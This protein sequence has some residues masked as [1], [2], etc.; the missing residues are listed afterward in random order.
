MIIGIML[1]LV[2]PMISAA[3]WDSNWAKRKE[4]TITGG[5]TNLTNFTV[6]INVTYTTLMQTDFQDI[7]FID[8]ACS[9]AQTTA[10]KYELAEN[11]TSKNVLVYVKI[12]TLATGNNYIC[13]YYNNSAAT[14]N[15]DKV[16][17]WDEN[18]LAVYHFKE[19][20]GT[21][22]A[23]SKGLYNMSFVNTPV[24]GTGPIG[25]KVLL[26][27]GDT[28]YLKNNTPA[29]VIGDDSMFVEAWNTVA[30]V[31]GNKFLLS[32]WSTGGFN[33]LYRS[34]TNTYQ[35][36]VTG[37]GGLN[38][39]QNFTRAGT[40]WSY[41]AMNYNGSIGGQMNSSFAT[42]VDTLGNVLDTGID[43]RFGTNQAGT[44]PWDGNID[45]VRLSS[46]TRTEAWGKR[47]Y[48]NGLFNT[49]TFGPERSNAEV[50]ELSQ[51]Y[52][53]TTYETAIESM[54]INITYDSDA[55]SSISA[56][57]IYNGTYY[58]SNKT[59]TGDNLTFSSFKSIPVQLIPTNYSFYWNITTVN[60]SGTFYAISST[61]YQYVNFTTFGLCNSTNA[62]Q[63]QNITF[64][65]ET[66]LAAMNGSIDASTWIYWLG[67]GGVN[68]TYIFSNTSQDNKNFT[69]CLTP[70]DRTL[71]RLATVQ[72]SLTN[73]PQRKW[74]DV[75]DLT[76]AS[77]LDILYLLSSSVGLYSTYSVQN[78]FGTPLSDVYVSAEKLISGTYYLMET[79]YTDTAGA[80][81][82]WLDPNYEHRFI[83]T[84]SGYDT[85]TVTVR[86]SSST[87][88]VTLSETSTT[89]QFNSSLEGITWIYNSNSTTTNLLANTTYNFY[90]NFSANLSNIV[91]CKIEMLDNNSN[92]ISTNTTGCTATG[93]KV[94]LDVYTASNISIRMKISINVGSG[95]MVID[96]DAYWVIMS[97]TTKERGTIWSFIWYSKDLKQWGSGTRGELSRILL[98]YILLFVVLAWISINTNY[99]VAS[100]G[101]VMWISCMAIWLFSAVGF[102]D[103]NY[104][105]ESSVYPLVGNVGAFMN[106]YTIA[107]FSTLLTLGYFFNHRAAQGG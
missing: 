19:G 6:L 106:K 20:G 25:N 27:A 71:S 34:D 1:I 77:S 26:E 39:I 21:T 105:V 96:N 95:Y 13:M 73:Y 74:T 37:S 2:L 56:K 42:L 66:T 87:Y 40:D 43:F 67:N 91:A 85:E 103:L 72:Y 49:F 100:A 23:D 16:N 92:I 47:S 98:F 44:E 82:F 76:N 38:Q 10:L 68:K 93:G 78:Q 86:P 18:Y 65:D 75:S 70:Q 60:S 3:W 52:N 81:T 62:R 102:L 61:S 31:A 63:Y 32:K 80:I 54:A 28:D 101:G 88:T 12:P 59:G 97:L 79:G 11:L 84:K 15:E 4:I 29:P 8:G 17:T 35:Y 30:N 48:Q 46:S 64:K 41:V 14:N 99:D 45:E 5:D 50:E 33:I 57:L 89:A 22:V 53:G 36:S 51:Q 94:S 24:W 83:F 104:T 90:A 107:I 9:G 7:R 69:F 55:Y 58:D